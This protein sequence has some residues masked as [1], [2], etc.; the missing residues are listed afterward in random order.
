VIFDHLA[1]KHTIGIYPL[2]S[3][4]SCHLLAVDFDEAEWSD[5]VKAFAQSCEEL[6]VPVALEI[7]HSGKGAHAWIFFSMSVPAR[8]ARQLVSDASRTAAIAREVA[9]AY[10]VGR[11][12]LVLTERTGHVTAITEALSDRVPV[13]FVLH[14]RLSK[15]AKGRSDRVLGRVARRRAARARGDRQADWRRVRPSGAGHHGVGDAGFVAGH[16]AAIR[17]PTESATRCKKR[18]ANH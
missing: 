18:R 9:T 3:D 17:R 10:Q 13:P 12:V 5:D 7:S 6:D 2:L 14:G 15:K 4:D 16:A 1:G 11:K 8:D